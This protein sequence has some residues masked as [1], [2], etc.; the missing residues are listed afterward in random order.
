MKETPKEKKIGVTTVSLKQSCFN[1]NW[2]LQLNR[3]EQFKHFICLICKQVAN[4]PIEIHCQEHK[5]IGG[6]FLVGESCLK[7]FLDA[8]PNSCPIQ[9]HTNCIY[10]RS[11]VISQHIDE[12]EVTC[13]LQFQQDLQ[14]KNE[15]LTCNF[16]GKIKELDNHLNDVCALK[17]L[18]CWYKQFGCDHSCHKNKLHYHLCLEVKFHFDLVV[19]FVETLQTSGDVQTLLQQLEKKRSRVMILW[20]YSSSVYYF[21]FFIQIIIINKCCSHT[22][23][24]FAINREFIINLNGLRTNLVPFVGFVRRLNVIRKELSSKRTTSVKESK[25]RKNNNN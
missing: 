8:N 14:Q 1:K 24:I 20:N 19:T 4:Y 21:F 16:K 18:D 23:I 11:D 15:G 25:L 22:D 6:S 2:I 5:G 12:S 9:P 7:Q 17:M 3:P 10:Y 13:P